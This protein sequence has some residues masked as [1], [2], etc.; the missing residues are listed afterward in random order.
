MTPEQ[1]KELANDLATEAVKAGCT[2]VVIALSDNTRSE[3]TPDGHY[4]VKHSHGLEVVGLM[5]EAV[6]VVDE[7]T[8]RRRTPWVGTSRSY[9]GGGPGG[10]GGGGS[11]GGSDIPF[12][13][14][15]AGPVWGGTNVK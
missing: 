7:A 15:G 6:G 3:V 9:G 5:R 13:A 11:S 8:G 14:G 1:L 12:G 4:Y 10:G 2:G